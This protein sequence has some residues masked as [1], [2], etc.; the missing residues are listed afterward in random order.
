VLALTM[1]GAIT[2]GLE[3]NAFVIGSTVIF[4]KGDRSSLIFI[5]VFKGFF[6]TVL[7][8]GELFVEH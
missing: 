4:K 7:L 2:A 3:K 5:S 1:L 6:L 8:L